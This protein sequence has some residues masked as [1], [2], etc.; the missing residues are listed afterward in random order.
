[1]SGD[2]QAP[3]ADTAPVLIRH[4]RRAAP[5]E[6]AITV[7]AADFH[8]ADGAELAA[9][10]D[11]DGWQAAQATL[12]L[13]DDGELTL[14]LPN[15]AGGDGI[16]HRR[17]FNLLTDPLYRLGEE[18]LEVYREPVS[19]ENLLGVWATARWRMDRNTLELRGP[20][21]LALYTLARA[22]ELDMWH[23]APR[24]VFEHYT[25]LPVANL[26]L[27]L[28]A[29][30]ASGAG[31]IDDVTYVGLIAPGATPGARL[32]GTPGSPATLEHP[33][34]G[35]QADNFE[36]AARLAW[37]APTP[38]STAQE[39][40]LVVE[41]AAGP[42]VELR[43]T[44][45]DGAIVLAGVPIGAGAW[46]AGGRTQQI[47]PGGC[48]LR[49][50]VRR[51]WVYAF[52]EGELVAHARRA[53]IAAPTL[54]RVEARE[55]TIVAQRLDAQSLAPFGLRGTDK[56]D[57]VLPG[58][59]TPG[60]LRGRY[61]LDAPLA[62]VVGAGTTAHL[63]GA[64]DDL[65]E[66]ADS[67]LDATVDYT[68]GS[69]WQPPSVQPSSGAFSAR[70]TGAI[71]LDL[72]GNGRMLRL[73]ELDGAARV[74]VG[75]TLLSADAVIDAW[76]FAAVTD[77]RSANLQ[78]DLGELAGWYPIVVEYVNDSG[79][80][81]IRLEDSPLD[82]AGAPTG[83]ATV[84][85]S[86]L[87]PLGILEQEVRLDSHR[88]LLGAITEAFGYQWRVEPR[89]LESGEF[90][91]QIIPR[92]R[93]G[94]DTDRIVPSD[95]AAELA[96]EGDAT[97]AVD[98]LLIDAAGL[99]DPKAGT[100]SLTAD[101]V[102]DVAVAA[103][104]LF[105]S[106]G[107]ESLPDITEPNLLQ[108]RAD[109]IL[110]LKATP[111]EQVAAR[112][113]DAGRDLTDTFPLTGA[114]AR[115]RWRPGDGLRLALED[116]SVIDLTPRQLVAVQWPLWRNGSGIPT[117]GWRQRP[118]G[119]R[120]FLRRTAR[121]AFAGQRNPQGQAGTITGTWASSAGDGTTRVPLPPSLGAVADAALVVVAITGTGTLEVNGAS[122][123]TTTDAAGRYPLKRYVARDGG[124]PVMRA[125]LAG[126]TSYEAFLELRVRL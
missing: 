63:A 41:F 122:T 111:N 23:H 62:S 56:G 94:T 53:A 47:K 114:L 82:G 112:P 29:W 1:M 31:T 19:P 119:L 116:L 50:L 32:Q 86:R 70:W 89:T 34:A 103:G 51:E 73:A 92:V 121:V 38:S 9:L 24:D 118:R 80:G 85:S 68:S 2:P 123:G 108:R 45:S 25:R 21:L 28:T 43:Y 48:S 93:V 4:V 117:V 46:R 71:Y 74:W 60:G 75:R 100:D 13:A 106:T 12:A 11:A 10:N 20:D 58:A 125:E 61:W 104:H 42:D 49:L 8:P 96:S 44:P 97:D 5:G 40:R 6:T 126:A 98:R 52:L 83:W 113:L 27:D 102:N 84:P 101:V 91:G 109:S 107:S 90:P 65:V 87:S 115:R 124:A 3:I 64:L 69:S 22:S 79:P 95:R 66:P 67:R 30:A 99:A 37:E 7:L 76:T 15:A 110:A 26:A 17:R 36:L 59:P 54:M 72:A 35:A 33:L 55:A 18:W 78:D 88:E 16:L 57:L 105:L 81:A 77:V 120:A 14:T 39:V